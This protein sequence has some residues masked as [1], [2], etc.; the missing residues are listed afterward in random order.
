MEEGLAQDNAENANAARAMVAAPAAE[1]MAPSR[2]IG[3]EFRQLATAINGTHGPQ[4]RNLANNIVGGDG[5][6]EFLM[7]LERP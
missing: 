5:N 6:R 3:A 1:A 7:H 4:I 2:G